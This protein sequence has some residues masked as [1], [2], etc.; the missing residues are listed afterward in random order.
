MRAEVVIPHG[1]VDDS[2]RKRAREW[3]A[4]R[5]REV[6]RLPVVLAECPDREWSKGA[7]ANP[8]IAS[9]SADVVIVADA[10]SYVNHDALD[11]SIG[12]ALDHGWSMPHSIVKRWAKDSTQAIYKG[13]QARRMERGGYPAL[14]GGGI[15]VARQ[16]AWQAVGG[17]FDPR[18]KGWGGEDHALGLAMSV[19]VGTVRQRRVSALWH[20]WHP[21]APN[22]RRPS[23]ETRRLNERYRAARKDP[24]AMSALVKEWQ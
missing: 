21:P 18:H 9:S 15:V 4:D 17:G 23:P 3:V 14:P 22:N 5:Y 10:D 11:W 6:H 12:A 24:Q 1:C 20:L 13:Q 7:A 2:W 19:L 8:A 16:D